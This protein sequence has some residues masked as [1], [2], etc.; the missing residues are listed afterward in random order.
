MR[1]LVAGHA[2]RIKGVFVMN[3]VSIAMPSLVR[4]EYS[5][6]TGSFWVHLVEGAQNM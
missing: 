5:R 1:Q 3:A 2:T 4:K 6:H